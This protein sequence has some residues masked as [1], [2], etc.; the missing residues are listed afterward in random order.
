MSDLESSI[1]ASPPR[2]LS[3]M[4]LFTSKS[5]SDESAT[6]WLT[7]LLERLDVPA[8]GLPLDCALF[9]KKIA[10]AITVNTPEATPKSATVR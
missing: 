5:S 2:G 7:R 9:G 8:L 1:S 3:P 4:V 10:T 6:L